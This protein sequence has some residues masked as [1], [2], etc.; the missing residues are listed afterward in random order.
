MIPGFSIR[1]VRVLLLI[2]GLTFPLASAQT[3]IYSD[4]F[5]GGTGNI[6]TVAPDVR[7]G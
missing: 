7:P 3:T 5:D 2:A 6:N 4:N 1:C